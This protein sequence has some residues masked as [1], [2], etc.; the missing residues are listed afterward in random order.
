[1]QSPARGWTMDDFLQ[2]ILMFVI[3]AFL[4]GGGLTF[5]LQSME[6]QRATFQAAIFGLIWMMVGLYLC[7]WTFTGPPG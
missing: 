5:M 1:M 7:V 2:R 6:G 3:G 4:V